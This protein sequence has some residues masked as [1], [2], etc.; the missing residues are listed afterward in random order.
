MILARLGKRMYVLLASEQLQYLAEG[1][2]SSNKTY[3]NIEPNT[4]Y[5]GAQVRFQNRDNALCYYSLQSWHSQV[6]NY[7][8]PSRIEIDLIVAP[9]SQV[10]LAKGILLAPNFSA[11]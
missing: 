2:P 3:D 4:S 7:P 6:A 9:Q 10:Y 8:P 5:A 1:L 11:T